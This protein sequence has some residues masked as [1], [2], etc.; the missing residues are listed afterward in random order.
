MGSAQECQ[1]QIEAFEKAGASY[2][3]LYP[4][5]IDGDQDRGVRA[6]LNAFGQ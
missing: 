6:A 5:A 4:M 1:Q 3:I 2:V